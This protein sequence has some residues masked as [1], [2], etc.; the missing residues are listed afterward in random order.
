MLNKLTVEE[1]K[2]LKGFEEGGF[3]LSLDECISILSDAEWEIFHID[4]ED[5]EKDDHPALQPWIA[6]AKAKLEYAFNRREV[7]T[8]LIARKKQ[9]APRS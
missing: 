7:V 5:L 1:I 2:A 8:H 3:D 4:M 6:Q 9:Q